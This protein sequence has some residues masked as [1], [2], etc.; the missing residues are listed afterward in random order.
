MKVNWNS[1]MTAKQQAK[2]ARK[3]GKEMIILCNR[4]AK[5]FDYKN[6]PDH[7]PVLFHSR[8]QFIEFCKQL[9]KEQ[10]LICKEMAE[11]GLKNIHN[12]PMPEI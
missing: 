2:I 5:E 12:A 8:I 6:Y 3:S 7:K 10:S 4:L 11:N 1:I 9:C